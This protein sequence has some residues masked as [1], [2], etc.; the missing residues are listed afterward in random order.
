MYLSS[1]PTG[2]S[3]PS[4]LH[5]LPLD[6]L[7]QLDAF[8][9]LFDGEPLPS[10]PPPRHLGPASAPLQPAR[11]RS[12]PPRRRARQGMAL[13]GR[14]LALL[15]LLALACACAPE[16][17][18]PH[19]GDAVLVQLRAEGAQPGWR[20]VG[21][22][23]SAVLPVAELGGDG[24]PP[25]LRVP[26]APG[27]DP[28][29]VA[30]ELSRDGAVAFAEPVYLYQSSRLPDDARFKEQWGL[31][32]MNLPAAWDHTVGERRTV[33]AVVDDGVAL[34]HPDLAPNLWVN[35]DEEENGAD[36]DGDGF[37]DD[38]H[39]ADLVDGDGD[40]SPAPSGSARWHGSHV[41]GTIGAASNNG[42]GVAGVSWNVSL[43]A[44]RGL[45]P[46]GGRADDLARAIDYASSHGAR[47][48]NASW[49][50]GGRSLAI[51]QA[52]AR[53]E[54]RGALFVAAAG[55]EAAAAPSFP[56]DL[57]G[58]NVISV[59]ATQP[60]D[61]LAPFSNRGALL[62]APGTGILSTT[63]PGRYERYDGTSMAA[64]HVSG[65]AALLWSAH[66][67]AA[68]AQVRRALV[69]SAVRVPGVAWGRVDAAAALAALDR[70]A[71]DAEGPLSLSRTRLQFE[72]EP[73]GGARAQ[74][75]SVRAEGGG[76]VAFTA[77]ASEAWVRLPRTA[78]T[79]PARFTV[80]VDARGLPPGAHEA[81]VSFASGAGAPVRL[82][83]AV[84]V[85]QQAQV[86]AQGAR[87]SMEAGSLR[88]AAGTLCTLDASALA[89]AAPLRW[90]EGER[91]LGRGPRLVALFAKKGALL[92]RAGPARVIPVE[93]E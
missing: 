57:A 18:A 41:A 29:S 50:G 30:R 45:G 16:A 89:T 55:N 2:P 10:L 22:H 35:P 74:V 87:C 36:D 21:T 28:R 78:A 5:A 81:T 37:V 79:T 19:A 1:L 40:P 11:P 72:A 31:A 56:A 23:A 13:P 64:P 32:R 85:V 67:R 93:V 20:S 46:E 8:D 12:T 80:D 76:A 15:G 91:E 51:E 62:A 17:A 9:P 53:A 7:E 39:G 42:K 33:V 58:A 86:T 77:A 70:L 61:T 52:V 65:L 90:S 3:R 6:L 83:V 14:Q 84:Q 73:D 4:P 26:V 75:I 44:V 88:V 60:D 63:A 48:I 49:G 59:G 47:V 25:L 66:P 27:E 92:L 24:E 54:R 71:G 69:A 43:M 82:S 34:D 68:V 38:V